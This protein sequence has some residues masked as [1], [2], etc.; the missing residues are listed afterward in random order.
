MEPEPQPPIS[1]R[2][3][4]GRSF[5]FAL[6]VVAFAAIGFAML[7][8][9]G[10]PPKNYGVRPAPPIRAAGWLNGKEPTS[11][12]L[13]G[14]VIVVDAWAYWCDVCRAKAPQLVKLHQTYR[15]RGVVFLGLTPEGNDV[16]AKNKKFLDDVKFTW[17][18][19]YGATQTLTALN[20]E[21][22]PKIWVIDR[23]NTI[24]WETPA[25]EPIE[26]AIE[27]ALAEQQ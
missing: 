4:A 14:K 2:P 23:K 8:R 11:A 7:I 24:I 17:P 13:R 18:S 19:G 21:V 5:G 6:I 10:S 20:S 15:D 3:N 12:D 27:R 25:S 9:Q 16:A 26:T 1:G 22:L